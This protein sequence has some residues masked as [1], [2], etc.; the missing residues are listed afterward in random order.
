MHAPSVSPGVSLSKTSSPQGSP[1]LTPVAST[2]SAGVGGSLGGSGVGGGTENGILPLIPRPPA[3]ATG[4]PLPRVRRRSSRLN[5][6][7]N[8]L[9]AALAGHG[10]SGAAKHTS[11]RLAA[12][13]A[14]VAEGVGRVQGFTAPQSRRLEAVCVDLDM[15]PEQR[16]FLVTKYRNE[17]F[18]NVA[19]AALRAWEKVRCDGGACVGADEDRI[20]HLCQCFVGLCRRGGSNVTGVCCIVTG[21]GTRVRA[22]ARGP[23]FANR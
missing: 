19:D 15:V 21:G 10:S 16:A 9:L 2:G 7:S 8:N 12:A 23:Q 4:A 11:P 22:M 6:S 5:I 17:P 20:S 14:A 3:I 13:Q 18:V 1:R